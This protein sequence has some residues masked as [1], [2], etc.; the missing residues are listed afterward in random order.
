MQRRNKMFAAVAVVSAAS[1]TL[2]G[3]GG[4]GAATDDNGKPIVTV[5]SQINAN[6]KVKPQDQQWFKDIEAACDCTLK[7]DTVS[8]GAW[9]NQKSAVLASGEVADINI[10]LYNQSELA[11]SPYFEDLSDDMDSLPSVK[12]F[13]EARDYARK[14]ATVPDTGK[15]Y[16]IPNDVVSQGESNGTGQTFLIN[17][18]WLDKLG[19]EIPTTWDE[20][21]TV[22]KAFKTQDPN[23]NGEADEIPWNIRAMETGGFGWYSPFQLLNS[24]GISTAMTMASGPEGIYVQ[25]GKVKNFLQTE[26]FRDVVEFLHKLTEEDLIPKAGWTKDNSKWNSELKSDGK[27]AISGMAVT[28]NTD[29]FGDLADQYVSFPV[30]G[31]NKPED[32]TAEQAQ[33]ASYDGIAV[34]ADAPNKETIFKVVEKMMDTDISIGQFFGS[35]GKYVE[36]LGDLHYRINLEEAN[37]ETG[38]NKAGLGNRGYSYFPEGIKIENNTGLDKFD[39]ETRIYAQQAPGIDSDDYMPGYVTPNDEDSVTIANNRTQILN[40]VVTQVSQWVSDGGL[41]D[42]TWDEFQEKIKS[43]GVDQN[44]ELWQK[45]YDEYAKI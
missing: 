40:Y 27:T 33:L 2:A 44:V 37:D 4:E 26:N 45:W 7:W 3:C 38:T 16:Q 23:G 31:Q 15:I 17:K 8:V 22:L 14:S 24:T 20:L 6:T 1:M 25:D 18:T 19:L 29:S 34:K 30:P 42:Q 39:Q 10:A 5:M 35:V 11:G 41:T 32:A 43:L 21:Y 36:K 9:T 12:K 13:F 28:W